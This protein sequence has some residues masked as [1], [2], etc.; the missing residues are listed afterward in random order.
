SDEH[1][2]GLSPRCLRAP[3]AGRHGVAADDHHTDDTDRDTGNGGDLMRRLIA[4]ATDP[5][6]SAIAAAVEVIR[7]GGVVAYPTDTLY[8]LAVDPR[9]N[10]AVAKLF[11]WKERSQG[12]GIPL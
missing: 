12:A 4:S 7:A 6:P 2:S 11:E 9:Q 1:P 10:D 3:R 8:G 5:D